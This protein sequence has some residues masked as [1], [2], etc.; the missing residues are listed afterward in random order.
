MITV[1]GSIHP[2]MS[3][4]VAVITVGT[5]F[6]LDDGDFLFLGR[7]EGDGERK[8]VGRA[9]AVFGDLDVVELVVS[10]EV[11]VVVDRRC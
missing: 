10:I 2:V 8:T 4:G 11:E 1:M 7:V 3:A 5:F 6:K 9:A